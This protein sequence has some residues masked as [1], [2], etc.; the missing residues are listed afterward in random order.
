MSYCM[1]MKVIIVKLCLSLDFKN[2]S[3][4]CFLLDLSEDFSAIQAYADCRVPKNTQ[5]LLRR[6][7]F[8]FRLD[9]NNTCLKYLEI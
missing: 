3:A 1:Q 4:T 6:Y 8:I 7:F 5:N 9:F 2:A